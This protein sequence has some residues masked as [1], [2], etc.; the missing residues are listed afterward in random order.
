MVATAVHT[1][2]RR[3]RRLWPIGLALVVLLV[4]ARI[5]VAEPFRISGTSMAP[6]LRDGDRVLVDKRAY[7]DGLPR[8]GDLV[9]FHAP[10]SGDVTLKRVVGVPGDSV[11]IEDGVLVVN[12]A[13]PVEPYTT[14]GA[15]D[16]VYFGPRRVRAASVFVL[17]DNRGDSVDS[18]EYGLVAQRDL[19][20][21]VGARLW[22][23]SR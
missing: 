4:L 20:G 1:R 11:A 6:T 21:R 2:D 12:G 16:T 9:V 10:T 23:P 18:R 17:G 8:R 13:R 22:P 19:I 7:R 3:P 15:I 14:P 5:F